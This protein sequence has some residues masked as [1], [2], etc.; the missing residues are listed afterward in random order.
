MN[1]GF[2]PAHLHK[3]LTCPLEKQLLGAH[4]PPGTVADA[5]YLSEETANASPS[6]QVTQSCLTLCDPMDSS[7]WNSPGQNTGVGTLSLLQ[8]IFP[9]QRLNPGLHISGGFFISW[10]T[11]KPKNTGVGRLSFLQRIF[12]TQ[13]LNRGGHILWKRNIIA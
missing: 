12:P 10:A 11:G 6:A 9:T 2:H 7:P 13:E 8:G 4:H 5:G 3:K 1:S